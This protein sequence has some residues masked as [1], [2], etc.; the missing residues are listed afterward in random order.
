MGSISSPF[1]QEPPYEYIPPFH[2]QYSFA[3][4]SGH[5]PLDMGLKGPPLTEMSQ[6]V[7]T[8]PKLG[9]WGGL[10][11][12]VMTRVKLSVFVPNG[13]TMMI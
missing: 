5:G 4:G 2:I 3:M 12:A 7:S 9:P 8:S 10:S 6:L 13:V 11:Y 1:P